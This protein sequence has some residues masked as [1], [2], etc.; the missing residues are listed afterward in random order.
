MGRQNKTPTFILEQELNCRPFVMHELNKRFEVGRH[1]YN[2]CVKELK[3]R[4]NLYIESKIYNKT[5]KELKKIYALPVS[6]EK[7]VLIRNAYNKLNNLKKDLGLTEYSMHEFVVSIKHNYDVQTKN[8]KNIICQ[9]HKRYGILDI[10]TVQKIATQAWLAM[11]KQLKGDANT[12]YFKKLGEMNSL[13]GKN[14][15]SGITLR[16]DKQG[17]KLIRWF[18]LEIPLVQKKNDTFSKEC[19][20]NH[21]IKY[22]RIIK[23]VIRG[24]ER[25]YAQM[26]MEGHPPTKKKKDG[27]IKHIVATQGRVGIDIGTSTIAVA[28]NSDVFLQDLRPSIEKIEKEIH[29]IQRHMDRSRRSTNPNKF[30]SDGT[31]KKGNKDKWIKSNNYKKAQIKLKELHR[32]KAN[33]LTL[34][35]NQLANRIVSIGNEIYCEKMNFKALAKRARKTEV[36][37]KTGRF[38]RKKRFGKSILNCAPSKLLNIIDKK[39]SYQKS[40]IIYVN[41]WKFKAS[42]YDH[43][44]DDYTKVPLSARWKEIDNK[45]IQRDLYSAFL[46]MNCSNDLEQPD[47][48]LCKQTFEI[49]LKLHEKEIQRILQLKQ[50]DKRLP[51]S[52]GFK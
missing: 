11:D 52:F 16:E 28:S 8:N 35:H 13:E 49:F 21:R 31:I 4:H 38:K 6:K 40:G 15:E 30:N 19:F 32:K 20:K 14:N 1:I 25:F 42:Q 5:I 48:Q 46:I 18:G 22:V 9:K 33:M 34:N 3:K 10:N 50:I 36:S 24:K 41:T 47:K 39:L 44:D 7:E 37:E 26:I 17:N 29:K 12:V 51:N 45:K 27:T 43:I 2:Y 23:R